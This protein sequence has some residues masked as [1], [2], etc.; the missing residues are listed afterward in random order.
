MKLKQMYQVFNPF[1]DR[2]LSV[3]EDRTGQSTERMMAVIAVIPSDTAG[4]IVSVLLD[5]V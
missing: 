1:R 4:V 3:F 2:Y 5:S